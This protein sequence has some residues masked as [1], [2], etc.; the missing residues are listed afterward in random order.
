VVKNEDDVI[1]AGSNQL[2]E[3]IVPIFCVSNVTGDGLELLTKFLHVLPPGISIKEKER[4]EQV[5]IF[6]RATMF[7]DL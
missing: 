7:P 4:L 6:V 2:A 5:F 3:N 1:T